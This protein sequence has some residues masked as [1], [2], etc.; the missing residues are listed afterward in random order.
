MPS[1]EKPSGRGIESGNGRAAAGAP[2]D[3]EQTA[4]MTLM[5]V[6]RMAALLVANRPNLT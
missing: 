3:N 6:L 5:T 4:T 1:G 2:N